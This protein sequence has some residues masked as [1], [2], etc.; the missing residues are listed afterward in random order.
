[1]LTFPIKPCW[2]GHLGIFPGL[3]VDVCQSSWWEFS[4]RYLVYMYYWITVNFIT[5][6]GIAIW[7]H[8]CI[9][10]FEYLHVSKT[11]SRKCYGGG[12]SLAN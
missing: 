5:E 4:I 6:K 9:F 12:L 10:Y 8:A 1:M 2:Y 11:D 3:S 7:K